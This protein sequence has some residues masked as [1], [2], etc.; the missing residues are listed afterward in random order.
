MHVSSLFIG[1]LVGGSLAN[2]LAV[3]Y[4]VH[5][6]RSGL[7]EGWTEGEVL[8]RRAILPM[9]IGLTQ[10]NLDKAEAWLNEVS[11]PNS[12]KYGKHWTTKQVADAFAPSEE[13]ITSVKAWLASEGIAENRIKHSKGKTWLEFDATADEAEKLLKAKYRIFN[14]ESGVKHVACDQYSIPSHLKSHVDLIRPTVHFDVPTTFEGENDHEKRQEHPAIFKGLGRP[15]SGTLPKGGW[16]LP[17]GH[18]R[19]NTELD[20][21]DEFITPN[22]LRAL[23][24]I[25]PLRRAAQGNSYGI[26][27]YTPQAYVPSDLDM[28]FKNFSSQQVG[29]RPILESIDGGVVQQQSQSFDYNGESDLDLQY[30]MALVY[31]QPV[32]LYQVGD[33]VAGASFNNFLDAI[34]A[35]YCSYDGGDDPYYD[36]EYPVEGGYQGKNDCGKFA[37]TKV[38]STSYSYN[39]HDL[40]PAYQTRQCH[41]YLKL[42]MM[43][44]SVLYSS[45]DYG[46]AGNRG[47]CINGTGE[48][49]PY[50]DNNGGRF[51]PS[52]PGSCPYITSVGA[53]QVKAN[54]SI[55]A[56]QRGGRGSPTQPEEACESVI[57][58]GGGFSNVFGLPDYQRNAVASWWRNHPPPYGADRFNN[59]Q[60]TRGFPDV[61]AN[62][63]NYV[64]AIDGSFNLIFGTSASSPTLG[65]I[66]TLV[67]DARLRAGKSTIG[68]INPVA[69]AHPEVFN[70][71]IDGNN[72]GC[73]TSGFSAAPGWDP[74]TGLGTPDTEKMIRLWL[75]MR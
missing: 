40:S 61:S 6:K 33:L 27:E 56:Y 12:K 66:L 71:I 41:E 16:R 75:S 24:R 51:N 18:R 59:S 74:V 32:T 60:Q 15:G 42:G 35:S 31:P 14:H 58:S 65:S 38:I 5:E 4:I 8:D 44:V 25:P 7:S 21:C 39:E 48:D 64:I 22:C 28:F 20:T 49:A 37:P 52:F 46:V 63:A 70:D 45:G 55:T 47:T 30:A 3:N 26:V 69:Y 11:H 23:Y 62:G 68:F 29:A 1:A 43:G 10:S 2:P 13:T 57:Y 9:K 67:N 73:G 34:D 19:L 53:T 72:P 50:R 54:T 36:A 17:H